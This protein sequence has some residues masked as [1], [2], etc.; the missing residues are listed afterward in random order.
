MLMCILIMTLL[1]LLACSTEKKE[2]LETKGKPQTDSTVA[3]TSQ[4]TC[5][6]C[7]MVMARTAMVKYNQDGKTIYFCSEYCRKNYLTAMKRDSVISPPAQ[8]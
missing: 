7:G 4:A 3:D 2:E 8:Q 6:G 1:S 5:P